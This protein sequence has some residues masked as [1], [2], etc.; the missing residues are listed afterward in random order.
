MTSLPEHFFDCDGVLCFPDHDNPA[1]WYFVPAGP[2]PVSPPLLQAVGHQTRLMLLARWLDMAP[3]R[4]AALADAIRTHA[5][6]AHAVQVQPARLDLIELDAMRLQLVEAGPPRLLAISKTSGYAPWDAVFSVE[7]EPDVEV[8]V[9]E[10]LEQGL[11]GRLRLTVQFALRLPTA[12]R[13]RLSGQVAAAP[14]SL[15]QSIGDRAAVDDA[16]QLI[17]AALRSGELLLQLDTALAPQHALVQAALEQVL[18][19]AC[20][21][22]ANDLGTQAD[23]YRQASAVPAQPDKAASAWLDRLIPRKPA[24]H[25]PDKPAAAFVSRPIPLAT[26]SCETQ[27]LRFPDPGAN[28]A[29]LTA[30][31]DLGDWAASSHP[32]KGA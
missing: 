2:V 18:K 26:E 7:L 24:R 3:H 16:R 6:L 22:V 11:A 5:G 27:V 29:W 30:L 9:R 13:A 1:L 8:L 31:T 32:V 17:D 25:P 19:Q 12:V 4:T 15:L 14:L 28:D 21:L 10:A 20:L 23:Q